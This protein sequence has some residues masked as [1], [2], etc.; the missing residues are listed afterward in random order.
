[1]WCEE[2]CHVSLV[3]KRQAWPSTGVNRCQPICGGT[4]LFSS[5]QNCGFP[6]VALDFGPLS[7]CSLL[8]WHVR[9]TGLS[10]KFNT[11]QVYGTGD[12]CYFTEREFADFEVIQEQMAMRKH[13]GWKYILNLNLCN[14]GFAWIWLFLF[15]F[16]WGKNINPSTYFYVHLKK[17]S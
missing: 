14:I 5:L 15:F 8:C 3:K 13:G 11:W 1:M 10:F 4:Y 16:K 2:T 12:F 6:A 7:M 17:N 9:A